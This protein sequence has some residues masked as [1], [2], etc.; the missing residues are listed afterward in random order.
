MKS[1]LVL[2]LSIGAVSSVASA[3]PACGSTNYTLAALA[4]LG[5]SCETGD[6]IFSAF[7]GNMDTVDPNMAVTFAGSGMGPYNVTLSDD[8]NAALVNSFTFSYTITV[9]ETGI[10]GGFNYITAMGAGGVDSFNSVAANNNL[11]N[12]A[13]CASLNSTDTG[14]GGFHTST[15]NT[16]GQPT[17]MSIAESYV[18]T[19]GFTATAI[20][21]TYVQAFQSVSTGS[22]EPGS[23]ILLGSGLLAAGLIGRKKLVRK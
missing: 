14:S 23:M 11:T 16:T 19:S 7:G 6:K 13:G 18:Y 10:V 2:L 1:F 12:N 22:P 4:A 21:D 8:T 15:C 9:D 17:S 20:Q 3:T 5:G